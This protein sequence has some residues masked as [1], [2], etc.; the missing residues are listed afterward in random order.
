MESSY[1]LCN[2]ICLEIVSVLELGLH[3]QAG[4]LASRCIPSASDLRLNHYPALRAED[5]E[6][7]SMSRISPHTDFGIISLLLQDGVGGLGIEDRS[8]SGSFVPVHRGDDC[9]CE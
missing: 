1:E 8:L 4:S 6:T 9:K 2:K 3:E 7:G 5:L